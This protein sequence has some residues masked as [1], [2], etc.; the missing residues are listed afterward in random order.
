MSTKQQIVALTGLRGYAA[1]W[2][3]LSHITFTDYLSGPLGARM[4]WG[5][6]EGVICHEYLA[7]D[8]FFM[9]SGFVLTHVHPE[10]D[11][12]VT[13]PA[14]WR[15][16]LLRVARV[17][18]LH[19]AAL[20]ATVT[21]MVGG[22]LPSWPANDWQSAA[23][24]AVMMGSWG[25]SKDVTWNVPAW[26]LSSE[27]LA[28]LL[29]PLV[30]MATY[31]RTLRARLLLLVGLA[32][33]F[34]FLI[35]GVAERPHYANGI[36]A[37]TRVIIGVLIGS[38]LRRLYDEPRVR[39]VWWTLVFWLGAL[40]AAASMSTLTGGRRPDNVWAWGSM[41]VLLF[42]AVYAKGWSMRPFTNRAAVYLGE[43]SYSVYIFHFPVFRALRWAMP[44]AIAR[45]TAGP[46][47]DALLFLAGS[48]ATVFLVAAAAHHTI[49]VPVRNWA[50]KLIEPSA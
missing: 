27:W 5:V 16:L 6:F 10:L 42:A 41:A 46:Q 3:M 38:F 28:Y 49:E 19:L 17:Y 34:A 20:V 48:L 22:K 7:V 1:I 45:A 33:A 26:S 14:Y 36:G 31:G 37:A 50:R 15:F 8:F 12:G 35:F 4:K 39:A 29:F 2:V 43:I 47:V 30:A 18:P 11:T 13:R 24:H 44:E 25:F 32:L 23:L 9:L 21:V 40:V